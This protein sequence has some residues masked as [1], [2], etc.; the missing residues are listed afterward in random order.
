MGKRKQAARWGD[1]V[2]VKV[3]CPPIAA[4]LKKLTVAENALIVKE[5]HYTHVLV[6]ARHNII[7]CHI[8]DVE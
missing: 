3:L 5:L 8:V 6:L 4:M 1:A 7:R 2:C